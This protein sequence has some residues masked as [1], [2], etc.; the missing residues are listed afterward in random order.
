MRLITGFKAQK[1]FLSLGSNVL[2]LT[3]RLRNIFCPSIVTY[4]IR[5]ITDLKTQKYFL[6]LDSNVQ[7]TSHH[8]LTWPYVLK[9]RVWPMY[10]LILM[11]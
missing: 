4:R 9:L 2:S 3:L 10:D 6:S 1:Y 8:W 11:L 7:N 5:L